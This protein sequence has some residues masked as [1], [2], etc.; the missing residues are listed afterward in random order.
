VDVLSPGSP[1]L[2]WNGFPVAFVLTCVIEI[3]AYV[4]AFSALGWIRPGRGPLSVR[5][6]IALALGVNLVTH[7]VLWAFALRAGSASVGTLL[8]ELVVAVVEGALIF[9][10]VRR[11]GPYPETWSN[12]LSW[13]MMVA[14]GVNTLSLLVGLVAMPLIIAGGSAAA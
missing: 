13:S 5:S 4:G 12:R 2:V 1:L 9:A 11:R 6:A 10:V 7:P 8:A 14:I 3:P